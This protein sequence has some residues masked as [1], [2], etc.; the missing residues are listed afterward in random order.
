MKILPGLLSL[1]LFNVSAAEGYTP[2]NMLIENN[3]DQLNANWQA[4]LKNLSHDQK[5]PIEGIQMKK[6]IPTVSHLYQLINED[7]HEIPTFIKRYQFDP[8]IKM[9]SGLT[10]LGYAVQKGNICA[11]EALL[12]AGASPKIPTLLGST[13]L[14]QAKS[15]QRSDIVK[16]LT[17]YLED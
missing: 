17:H 6:K 5:I 11:I 8:N 13:P 1:C 7:C 2:P 15:N 14:E 16:L 9:R 4:E 12:E 10:P 3:I